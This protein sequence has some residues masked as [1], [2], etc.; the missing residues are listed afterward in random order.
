MVNHIDDW[1]PN[2]Q[3]NIT[4]FELPGIKKHIN[5]DN[6]NQL[7]I[8]K[9]A[10]SQSVKTEFWQ[11][12]TKYKLFLLNDSN[13]VIDFEREQAILEEI[14]PRIINQ[15]LNKLHLNELQRSWTYFSDF[16]AG[17]LI[18]L[19]ISSLFMV[20]GKKGVTGNRGVLVIS[21]FIIPLVFI[22][23]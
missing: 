13:L 17:L 23:I 10:I 19:A 16:F 18:F 22:L 21:G 1:N 15:A 3:V 14:K 11:S 20:K 9:L 6:L 4:Q 5:S 12:P 7:I 2:Y 8:E